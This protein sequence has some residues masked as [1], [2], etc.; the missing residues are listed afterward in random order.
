LA[1]EKSVK[2]ASLRDSKTNE[3]TKPILVTGAAGKLGGVGFKIV[4]L[5]R[6][7]SIPVRA[8]VRSLDSRSDALTKL[9]AEVVKGD[10]TDLK[11]VLRVMDGCDRLYFGMS[12]SSSYLE[13]T[14][15][16]AAVAKHLGIEFFLNISQM[17]VSQMNIY[18]TTSS[19]QQKLHWL[20][21]QALNWSGLPV[22]HV[23]P[24][25]FLE[26]FFFL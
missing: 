9:G 23:R 3:L 13:A 5:L 12:V 1:S 24:T 4:E 11:D 18:E 16:V 21:E 25:V 14:V 19:T 15:N 17:T 2:N 7:Q 22:V 26:H 6:A 8:M 20:S 10:L